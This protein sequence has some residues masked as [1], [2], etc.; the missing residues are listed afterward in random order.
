[1]ESDGLTGRQRPDL[2]YEG[3]VRGMSDEAR[4]IAGLRERIRLLED[5]VHKLEQNAPPS[6]DWVDEDDELSAL[7]DGFDS[8]GKTKS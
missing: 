6:S 8:Y 4:I 2:F 5:R 7:G 1:M 3:E